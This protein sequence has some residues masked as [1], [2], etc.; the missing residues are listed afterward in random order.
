MSKGYQRR[1]HVGNQH[2]LTV[3]DALERRGWHTEQFGQGLFSERVRG[4]LRD[5]K[6]V[7]LVRWLPD[8]IAVKPHPREPRDRVV[9]VDA[10]SDERHDTPFFSLEASAWTHHLWIEQMW[11]LPMVYVWSDLTCNRA[12]ALK[13]HRYEPFPRG[14][15]NG[16]G[17]PFVLLR[18]DE[19]IPLDR[20]FGTPL[21]AIAA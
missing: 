17:T 19:Q 10:K 18:K 4:A 1:M 8:L 5:I 13:A 16:S 9:L 6:P 3:W 2:E 20:C 15:V 14:K 11:G 21:Q 12:S 7:T